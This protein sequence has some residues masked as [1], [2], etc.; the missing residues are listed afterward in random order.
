M[1]GAFIFGKQLKWNEALH[2]VQEHIILLSHACSLHLLH[3]MAIRVAR[4]FELCQ[5]FFEP[6]FC[7]FLYTQ[8]NSFL[9][10]SSNLGFLVPHDKFGIF[11]QQLWQN[12]Q[13]FVNL[14]RGTKKSKLDEIFNNE[15]S[16]VYR[17]IQNAGS[18]KI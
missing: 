4:S 14:S 9:N 2:L 1:N 16:I 3:N 6:A 13:N 10:I 11:M 8:E 15:I 5:I 18:N 7:I 17:K 12:K